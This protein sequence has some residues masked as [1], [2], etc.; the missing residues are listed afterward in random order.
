[1]KR[2][3]R[4]AFAMAAALAQLALPALAAAPELTPVGTSSGEPAGERTG[5]GTPATLPLTLSEAIEMALAH[6]PHLRQLSAL[7]SAASA[8]VR[9]ARA[10]RYPILDLAAGYTRNSDVP[11]FA[12]IY[13][14]SISPVT[15]YP[16]L[17]NN[18]RT[19][20][21]L[22]VPIYTGGRLQN[23]IS[24][25]EAERTAVSLDGQAGAAD[26]ALETAAAY[27]FLLTA[28]S[29]ERTLREGIASYEA[30]LKQT[31]D[32]ESVG[33]AAR[34]DVLSVLVERDR[35][36]LARLRAANF[37]GTA[38]ANLARLLGLP[39]GTSVEPTEPIDAQQEPLEDLESLVAMAL[40]SRPERHALL[41]RL[42]GAR[43]RLEAQKAG[44]LPEA[45]VW[46]GYDWANPNREIFPPTDSWRST[47]DLGVSL[48]LSVFDSGRTSA[49]VAQAAHL[50]EAVER[51]VEDL[52]ER[53]RLEVTQ[54]HLDVSTARV[55]VDV[56][57]RNVEA[58][59]ENR[60]VSMDRYSEG[61][62][63]SSELLDS[64]TALLAAGL[65]LTRALA[66][67]R[68]ALV[69][70]DRATGRWS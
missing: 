68:L 13:P 32:R 60:R 27:W 69:S 16:N 38:D 57:R 59:S 28:R 10:Q 5:T 22:S 17:P 14:G 45:G 4:F 55:A 29:E 26:L 63:P 33:M 1:M 56:A 62:I 24:A 18:T 8:G 67:L 41:A 51:Q 50:V 40:S 42:S 3:L 46:A 54:R 6:S 25:A 61:M 36:E 37:A 2:F 44:W 70:L 23:T 11:E 65:D 47:W 35:A 49:A 7:E 20:L 52:E 12:I 31:R 43:A 58:A 66:Q 48:H 30:H 39:P 53:I 64:E 34:N 21:D 15:I 19:R 9:G